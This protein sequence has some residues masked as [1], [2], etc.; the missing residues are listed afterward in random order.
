MHSCRLSAHGGPGDRVG[1]VKGILMAL[2][3]GDVVALAAALGWAATTVM[4]RYISRAMPALWYNA[5][6]I[7][8]AA[9]VLLA[10][11]PWTLGRADL[12]QLTFLGLSFL[13][14]SVLTGFAVGD[15]SFFESMRRIGVARAAPVAGCHPLVTAVLAVAFLGEPVTPV[16]MLGI[17]TIGVGVWLITTDKAVAPAGRAAGHA[18]LVGVVLALVAAV[19]WAGSTV[20]VRPALAEIDAVVASTIRLPFA[21]VVLLLAAMRLRGFD[22]RKVHLGAGTSA[23]LLFA[24]L[25]TVVSAT[26]F[27]WSVELAGAARTA[28]ISSVSPVFS[29]TMAVLLLGEQM[30]PRLAIGM[31]ISLAGVLAIVVAG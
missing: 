24:G 10:V 31:A 20:L 11:S 21:T 1:D 7:A 6:R 8:I 16:L 19:G 4:A 28:A 30:T 5:L 2:G 22:N 17:V 15:T 26:L 29:A 25:M 23:W 18:M 27:L 13:L 9:A 3:V 14:M 12:S